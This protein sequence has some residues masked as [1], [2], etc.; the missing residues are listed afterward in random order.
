M[1]QTYFTEDLVLSGIGIAASFLVLVLFIRLIKKRN[2]KIL[3]R[4]TDTTAQ[5]RQEP[6][7][8][9][10]PTTPVTPTVKTWFQRLQKGLAQTH[11]QIVRGLDEFLTT[12][13]DRS[14]RDETL[15]ALF[16]LL[17][18]AD[19]GVTTSEL[20]V[21]R[22]KSRLQTDQFTNKDLF[23]D[24]LKEELLTI[25]QT[26]FENKHGI[27]EAPK[28]TPHVVLMVGVNGTGKT[29]TT[30]KLAHK[31]H[32]EHKR[33]I[34]GAADTFR[35]AA[36]D[37]LAVWAQ[38]ASATLVEHKNRA[39]PASVAFDAAKMAFEQQADLCLI[40]TAGRL[41]TRQDLMQELSKIARVLQKA[42]P[43]T[44]H[45]VLL[46]LDATTGQNALQQAKLFKEA[47]PLTG[48]VLTK[49]DGTAKGGI[50]LA[51]ANELGLP[52]R[53]VGVGES[54]DDLH[55]FHASEFIDALFSSE[56]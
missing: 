49:L 36:T 10:T 18:K 45:E 14:A 50:V 28:Y 25:L 3:R 41:Q 5:G 2:Q 24:I 47:V 17:I 23:Q 7:V 19:V 13:G 56:E 11:L 52:I 38:R 37:Q 39:D 53:Y 21:T 35:A 48:I 15:E 34:I 54:G 4:P 26:S 8:V 20:L 42:V 43:G 29:T 31:A 6:T 12:A 51:I 40:D 27:I 33:V 22:V 16:E 9:V 32:L 55:Q 30:G 44:P 46:V 1:I